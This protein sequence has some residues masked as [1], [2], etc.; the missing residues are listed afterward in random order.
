MVCGRGDRRVEQQTPD[1][2]TARRWRDGNVG[3]LTLVS[4]E[5]RDNITDDRA[6]GTLRRNAEKDTGIVNRLAK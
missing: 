6:P 3:D 5:P 4:R 1:A 2:T